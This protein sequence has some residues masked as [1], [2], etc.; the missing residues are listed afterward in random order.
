MD[1]ERSQQKLQRVTGRAKELFQT[2]QLLRL[3]LGQLKSDVNLSL[4]NFE[5]EVLHP[6]FDVIN[7]QINEMEEQRMR[8]EQALVD[9]VAQLKA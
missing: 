9:Q 7:D 6:N 1:N 5:E 2:T 4:A 8:R 3:T